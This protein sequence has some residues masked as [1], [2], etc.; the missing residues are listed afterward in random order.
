MKF[1]LVFKVITEANRNK[2]MTAYT[3]FSDVEKVTDKTNDSLHQKEFT[4]SVKH[5]HS[6]GEYT[7]DEL[8]RICL[9]S[10]F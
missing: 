3:H 6:I 8:G 9:I 10:N 5:Q 7:I 4:V 1:A 2:C